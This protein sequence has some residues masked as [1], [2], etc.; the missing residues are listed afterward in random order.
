MSFDPRLEATY[1]S[2]IREAA[3]QKGYE[4]VR[5]DTASRADDIQDTI[6]KAIVDAD[7][8]IA[9]LS[10]PRPNVY[11]ELGIAYSICK[12]TIC[13]ARKDVALPFDVRNYRIIQYDP[14]SPRALQLELEYALAQREAY[15]TNPVVKSGSSYFDLRGQIETNLMAIVRERQRTEEFAAY[16]KTQWCDN[17]AIA[18]RLIDKMVPRHGFRRH[19]A[20]IAICG[21]GSIGKSTFAKLL[22]ERLEVRLVD[23]SVSILPTDSYMMNRATRASKNITGFDVAAHDLQALRRDAQRLMEGESVKVTPYDHSTGFHGRAITIQS[24]HVL[25]VEGIHSL[26]PCLESLT[27]YAAFILASK[28]T[29]KELKFLADFL[30]RGYTPTTAFEHSERE[31]MDYDDHVLQ[32]AKLANAQI[33]VEGYWRYRF[34]GVEGEYKPMSARQR[35]NASGVRPA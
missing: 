24:P 5:A 31:Y 33:S 21:A 32:Y 15:S 28:F 11:F 14:D 22:K 30:V 1:T 9:D 25:I 13:I 29:V 26:N 18:E 16:A 12:P 17:T 4:C 20:L 6:I 34:D 3:R 2:A 19:K 23:R 35:R 8:V 27:T 7:V 10:E